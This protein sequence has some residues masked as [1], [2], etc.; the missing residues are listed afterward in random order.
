M[1]IYVYICRHEDGAVRDGEAVKEEFYHKSLCASF[2]SSFK[3]LILE[4]RGSQVYF[5][6]TGNVTRRSTAKT[7]LRKVDK[8]V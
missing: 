1:Y 2:V 7:A 8:T 4:I 3:K 5:D 6:E